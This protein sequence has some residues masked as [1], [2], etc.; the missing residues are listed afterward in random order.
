M[1]QRTPRQ[2]LNKAFLKMKPLR[3]D[4]QGFS[5][6]V[7]EYVRRVEA[8]FSESE[9]F[10]KNISKE[11][12]LQHVLRG[13]NGERYDINTSGRADLVIRGGSTSRSDVKVLLEYKSP[14]NDAEMPRPDRLD[15]KATQELLLYYLR[16]RE[17]AKNLSLTY[18]VVTNGLEW[19]IWDA[20]VWERAFHDD[21]S[22]LKRF[23]QF[24]D[25]VLSDTRTKT[26]Y[27]EI[28]SP[29]LAKALPT[30]DYTYVDL[31]KLP[32]FPVGESVLPSGE[33]VGHSPAGKV[34]PKLIAAY[35]LFSG[36][37]LLKLPFANDSNSLNKE[38][39]NELLY[40]MGLEQYEVNNKKLI[41]RAK[42]GNRD[43]NSWSAPLII[44]NDTIFTLK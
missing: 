4:V 16:E 37:H 3:D 36:T 14:S 29:V 1:S 30:L 9:E 2:S 39:Y 10:H 5:E 31:R 23:Q 11:H 26:F 32:D 12:F 41:G 6:S 18:L 25:G 33:S 40:I 28:A 15:G 13:P 44:E 35:K 22:L 24:E 19:Y 17:T 43:S 8:S 27:S 42:E 34:P 20:Q 21:K 38:F 7:K